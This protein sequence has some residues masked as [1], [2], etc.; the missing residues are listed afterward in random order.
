MGSYEY[1]LSVHP[2]RLVLIYKDQRPYTMY[3][4]WVDRNNQ[5]HFVFSGAGVWL[6]KRPDDAKDMNPSEFIS[7]KSKFQIIQSSILDDEQ[8]WFKRHSCSI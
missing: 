2:D 6:I 8:I 1:E 7:L 3:V 4:D 5:D